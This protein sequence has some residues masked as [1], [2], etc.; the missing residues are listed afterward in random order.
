MIALYMVDY[1]NTDRLRKY[2]ISC[3]KEYDIEVITCKSCRKPTIIIYKV[4]ENIN[5]NERMY[6]P[7]LMDY[8][9]AWIHSEYKVPNQTRQTL[10]THHRMRDFTIAFSFIFVSDLYYIFDESPKL[11]EYYYFIDI[12]KEVDEGKVALKNSNFNYL[13]LCRPSRVSNLGEEIYGEPYY[14]TSQSQLNEEHN[15]ISTLAIDTFRIIHEIDRN[16]AKYHKDDWP[17]G[18]HP[19]EGPYKLPYHK[20]DYSNLKK[21]EI[22]RSMI[23]YILVHL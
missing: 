16:I 13:S 21:S 1:Q 22:L 14:L 11:K 9:D 17:Y 2:C 20:I 7:T 5:P 15:L 3:K 19:F 6:L 8:S 4:D 18:E 23:D 10:H 12:P